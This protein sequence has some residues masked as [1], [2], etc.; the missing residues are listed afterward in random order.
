VS[1]VT[2]LAIVIVKVLVGSPLMPEGVTAIR[3]T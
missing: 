2:I 1:S 3:L